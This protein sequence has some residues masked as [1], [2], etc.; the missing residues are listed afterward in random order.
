M[1][2]QERTAILDRL[3]ALSESKAGD[4]RYSH[5][6]GA[7]SF[8]ISDETLAELDKHLQKEGY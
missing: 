3:L 6:F 7:L 2:Y 1:T 5:A 8:F 4:L